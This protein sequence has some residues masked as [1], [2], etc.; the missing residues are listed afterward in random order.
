[1]LFDDNGVSIDGPVSLSDRTDQI[2]RF[3]ASGW[4]TIAV[5]GHDYDAIDEA[6]EAAKNV[7][8][9]TLIA[10]QTV[11]GYGAPTKA[12]TAAAHGA[13]LGTKEI[14][15]TR[16]ALDWS[17]EPFK[18]PRDAARL[19]KAAGA[20][21]AEEREA[22]TERFAQLSDRKQKEFHRAHAREV[23][24]RL[25]AAVKNFKEQISS[26]KPSLATRK[27]SQ[28]ALEV[29][30]GVIPETIGGS[31]DL[32]GSNNTLTDGLGV[33]TA[34]DFSGRYIHYGVRE[35][36]MAAAMNGHGAAR[37]V[38][39]LWRHLPRLHRLLS[40]GDPP[41]GADEAARRLCDDA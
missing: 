3:Q 32:T 39:A 10:C 18:I 11:I 15:K 31:A 25:S 37:R 35:H 29:L 5:D 38:P 40:S 4:A 21:G 13:P 26:E 24:S 36:A 34:G 19:W 28:M 41:L 17:E 30:N 2:Q 9:P 33:V 7:G 20:R 12:G 23:P 6:I 14:T 16:K 22:W 8:H 1:M 27:A